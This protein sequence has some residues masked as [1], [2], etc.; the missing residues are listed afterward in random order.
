MDIKVNPIAAKSIAH[1]VS[2]LAQV[3]CELW[4]QEDRAR[5]KAD[6]EVVAAKRNIGALNQRRNDLIEKIDESLVQTFQRNG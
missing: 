5:S 2:E 6:K 1:L 3:H 4:D